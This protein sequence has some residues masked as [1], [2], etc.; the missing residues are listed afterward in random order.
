M[1]IFFR[2][3]DA[4]LLLTQKSSEVDFFRRPAKM[5]SLESKSKMPPHI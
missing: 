3:V 2:I 4:L 5:D 1:D